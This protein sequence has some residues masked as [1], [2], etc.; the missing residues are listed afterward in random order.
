MY[1][2]KDATLARIKRAFTYHPPAGPVQTDR[3]AEIRASLKTRA[4][5]LCELC[6]EGRELNIALHHLE[7]AQQWAIAAIA[8]NEGSATPD[9]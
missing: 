5:R 6:P 4:L 2:P 1:R 9:E 7:D 8:R 3:Y